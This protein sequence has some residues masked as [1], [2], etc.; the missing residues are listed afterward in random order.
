MAQAEA[1]VACP[2]C[3]TILREAWLRVSMGEDAVWIC[4]TCN[5]SLDPVD[6]IPYPEVTDE[7]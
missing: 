3:G 5:V 6:P 1:A 2:D 4:D 7:A